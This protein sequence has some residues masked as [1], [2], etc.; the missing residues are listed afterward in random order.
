MSDLPDVVEVDLTTVPT[1]T[2]V[3]GNGGIKVA[4]RIGQYVICRDQIKVI[5][6]RHKK[7]LA[8]LKELQDML[9]GWLQSA[10]DKA[11]ADSIKSLAGTAYKTQK[12]TASLADPKA[13][14]DFVIANN[15]FDL[16][17]RKANVTAVKEY[18]EQNGRLPPGVN[19]SSIE[20]IGVRRPTK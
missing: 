12:F 2:P 6:E 8:P 3:G 14:M 19:L 9:G 13:F 16:M 15:L 17:D 5:E 4:E 18:V 7:E 10:L 1:T 11:G 20:T